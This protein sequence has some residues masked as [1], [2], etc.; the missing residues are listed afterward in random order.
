MKESHSVAG[1]C[2]LFTVTITVFGGIS[3]IVNSQIGLLL[4]LSNKN[5][6]TGHT[7]PLEGKNDANPAVNDLGQNG[8]YTS[9]GDSDFASESDDRAFQNLTGGIFETGVVPDLT[10][11][12]A[13]LLVSVVSIFLCCFFLPLWGACSARVVLSNLRNKQ[14]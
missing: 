14:F 5:S 1:S 9:G 13:G 6:T 8:R 11:A 2:L 10:L 4:K 3:M 12:G 7:K